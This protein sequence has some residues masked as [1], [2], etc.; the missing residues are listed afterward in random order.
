MGDDVRNDKQN[1]EPEGGFR[2][3]NT[4]ADESDTEGH[5]RRAVDE[6]VEPEGLSNHPRATEDE[7][8]AEGHLRR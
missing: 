4:P 6:P 7:D 1:V 2:M 8:D 5:L 3:G